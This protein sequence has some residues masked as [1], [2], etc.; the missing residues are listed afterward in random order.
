MDNYLLMGHILRCKVIPKNDVHPE[1]WIGSNKKF[2][3]IPYNKITAQKHN[4]VRSNALLDTSSSL[5]PN[6]L[7][8][9]RTMSRKRSREG[10]YVDKISKI[11]PVLFND[12]S[13]SEMHQVLE[14]WQ[15][16]IATASAFCTDFYP[17]EVTKAFVDTICQDK[18]PSSFTSR[19]VNGLRS[20]LDLN[21]YRWHQDH[22]NDAYTRV[23]P[24]FFSDMQLLHGLV[25]EWQKEHPP[26]S[27]FPA[28][29]LDHAELLGETA[30][31]C[32]S[33]AFFVTETGRTGLA[34]PEAEA[35][36]ELA[37]FPG[38]DEVFVL[39]EYVP[40]RDKKMFIGDARLTGFDCEKVEGEIE[41][42]ILG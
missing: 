18:T 4:K 29:S 32:D 33:R 24:D 35:G 27:R 41:D 21:F 17:Q 12:M 38:A 42:Y 40:G 3:R 16:L 28:P 31:K 39:R 19:K 7:R 37:W 14:A 5:V 23:D 36:D 11:G 20:S 2:K 30:E 34:H 1:L 10:Y 25:M 6:S 9:G 22:G 8:Q 13:T 15:G 26:T